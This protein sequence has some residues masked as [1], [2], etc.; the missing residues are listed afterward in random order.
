MTLSGKNIRSVV[1][2]VLGRG[3]YSITVPVMDG[4][5]RPNDIIEQSALVAEAPGID[6]LLVKGDRLIASAGRDL[7]EISVSGSVTRRL[8]FDGPISCLAISP[9]GT[10]AVGIDGV[11]VRLLGGKFD[12]MVIERHATGPMR[13]PTA[14]IF[15]DENTI[16]VTNGSSDVRA[17]DWA[18]D[19]LS[20][21]QSGTVVRF[22]LE[23]GTSVNLAF[24]LRFPSG[25]CFDAA[26]K[27]IIV[28]EAWAHRLI[29][30]DG[31]QQGPPKEVLGDLPAYPGRISA[32]LKSGFWLSCFA[33]RSQLQEFILSERRYRHVMMTEVEPRFWIAPTL[34][35]GHSFKEPLQEGGVIRLGIH[36]PWAPTRSYGLVVRLDA[37]IRPVWSAHSRANG[38]RHGVTSIAEFDGEVYVTAKGSGELLRIST[39]DMPSAFGP[40]LFQGGCI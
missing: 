36:K 33:V 3:G 6:N 30:L 37:D 13:C 15:E 9:M 10:I 14:A 24:G 40:A 17:A 2:W 31:G 29:A 39:V 21:G 25:L 11:G 8:R 38:V 18:R 20:I 12:G 4:P 28:S 35:S 32:S 23:R 7:L 1:E 19:L 22:V 34:S 5:L 26:N 16:V 27:R